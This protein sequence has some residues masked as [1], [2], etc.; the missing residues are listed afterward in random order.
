MEEFKSCL[1]SDIR[2]HLADRGVNKLEKAAIMAD[3]F[4]LVHKQSFG[5]DNRH[6]TSR[7]KLTKPWLKKGE[8]TGKT[9]QSNDS[10]LEL[11]PTKG[12]ENPVGSSE[13]SNWR[14]NRPICSF[15]GKIGHTFEKCFKRRDQ[16]EKPIALLASQSR[17]VSHGEVLL[18]KIQTLMK[19]LLK[20]R[21][22]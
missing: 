8:Q 1:P 19:F 6:G 11:D 17:G 10:K 2:T 12:K 22:R 4:E 21:L 18:S 16:F 13:R 20:L 5:S 14:K 7:S 3:D 9:T 15:C